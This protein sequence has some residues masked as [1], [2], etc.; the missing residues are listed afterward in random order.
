MNAT[1]AYLAVSPAEQVNDVPLWPGMRNLMLA[2]L[3]DAV[4]SLRSPNSLVRAEAELWMTSRESRYVFSF[5]VICEVL[6][7][8]PAAVRRSVIGLLDRKTTRGRLLRRSRPNVRHGG[9]I[10]PSSEPG[11]AL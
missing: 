8:Q 1:L 3:E 6:N 11:E 10:R 7:L 9:A 2:V 5:A 4:H